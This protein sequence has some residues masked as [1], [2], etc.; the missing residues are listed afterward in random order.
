MPI[1]KAYSEY[2]PGH[3]VAQL[4]P[5]PVSD[6]LSTDGYWAQMSSPTLAELTLHGVSVTESP[7]PLPVGNVTEFAISI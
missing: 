1:R 2:V 3:L 7:L 4:P 5:L 6:C